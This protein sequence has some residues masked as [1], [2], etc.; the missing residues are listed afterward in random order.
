MRPIAL[1]APG[2]LD[3]RTGGHIYN[4]RMAEGLRRR[5]WIVDVVELDASFP[6]PTRAALRDAARAFAAIRTGTMTVVDSLAF[7]AMADLL[8]CEAQRL[9][10]VALVHLPL[11]ADVSLDR[12][13]AARFEEEECRALNTAAL[14]VV[15][16]RA[17]LP[18]L[19]KYSLDTVRIVVIEPGTDR[20]PLA[21]GSRGRE[22][23]L[24]S[25]ATLHAGKGHET[26]LE[27]LAMVPHQE[28][29][30]TCAGSLTRDT[31]TADRVRATI[32]TLKLEDRVVLAGDLDGPALAA[33]YDRADVFVLASRQETYGMAV[34][35][36]LAHG[37]PVVATTTGAIAELVGN[38]AGLLVRVG[39][40]PALV[41]ALSRMLGDA[42]LRA[43]LTEGACRARERL[44]GWEEASA[45]MD[46]S[47]TSLAAHG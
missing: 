24:L 14:V 46:A 25:V 8:E 43:R 4:R 12:D 31:Q 17:A 6:Y 2:P 30:L 5:G 3:A 22:I 28:W 13:T 9:R 44:P 15:T 40:V 1:V 45:R 35:E 42:G 29:K 41:E 16:G 18:L 33:C 23:E 7:G 19:A 38:D 20:A 11:A 21:H 27:A 36:A 47:L 32:Q 37:L 10:I 26:L 34:A 39:D